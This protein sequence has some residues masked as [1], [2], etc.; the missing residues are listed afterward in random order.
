MEQPAQAAVHGRIENEGRVLLLEKQIEVVDEVWTLPGGRVNIGED[1]KEAL[2]RELWEEAKLDIAVGDPI[3]L[4]SFTWNEGTSGAV[5]TV[6]ECELIGGTVD[7][8][9]NPASEPIVDF[10][11]VPL[12]QLSK[13][14]MVPELKGILR[15][16]DAAQ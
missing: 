3:D 11:W 9:Q 12:S 2:V 14:P 10:G 13:F 6:F 15:E 7:I 16:T 1:P 8:S 5:A 4:Y